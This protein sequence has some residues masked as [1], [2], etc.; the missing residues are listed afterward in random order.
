MTTRKNEIVGIVGES[1]CGKSTLLKLLLRFW[2]R[3]GGQIRYH[4]TDIDEIN[5]ESLY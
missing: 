3:S 5:T 4:G 2:E 1:G